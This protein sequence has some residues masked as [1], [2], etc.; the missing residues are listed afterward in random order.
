MAVTP[1]FVRQVLAGTGVAVSAGTAEAVARYAEL[2][3]K[4]NQRVNLT[5]IADPREILERHFAESLFAAAAVPIRKGRLADVG[6]GAGFPGLA[7]RVLLPNLQLTLIE[8]NLKKTVFLAE[9][10]RDLS[11]NG[12]QIV[13]RRFEDLDPAPFGLDFVT[14][15]AASDYESILAWSSKA[16]GPQGS[17]VLW[18]G[19]EDARSLAEYPGFEWCPQIPLP[20]SRE[21]VLLVGRRRSL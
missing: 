15:R 13:R 8:P 12:V 2:L 18:L 16:L 9:V 6:T 20:G 21:R 3:L 11:L 5:S 17:V 10:C 1:E 4:W 7:L 14:S 19:A